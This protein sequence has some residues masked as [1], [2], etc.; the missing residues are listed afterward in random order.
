MLAR[1]SL[2]KRLA[3]RAC[4]S[5]RLDLFVLLLHHQVFVLGAGFFLQYLLFFLLQFVG[6]LPTAVSKRLRSACSR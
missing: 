4:A 2:L 1:N 5:S 6:A 3:W